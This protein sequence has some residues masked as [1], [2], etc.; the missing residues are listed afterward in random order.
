MDTLDGVDTPVTVVVVGVVALLVLPLPPPPPPPQ[1]DSVPVIKQI[2]MNIAS[3]FISLLLSVIVL[4][5]ITIDTLGKL[6]LVELNTLL[7]ILT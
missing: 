7:H 6:E 4:I 3:F 5:T 2:D 1:L